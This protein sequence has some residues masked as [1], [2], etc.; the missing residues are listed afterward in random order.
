MDVSRDRA[1]Q[2]Y[3]AYIRIICEYILVYYRGSMIVA[4][5]VVYGRHLAGMHDYVEIDIFECG[6]HST[7][8]V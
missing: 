6:Q 1:F 8:V 7:V 5:H 4:Q 2:R 3:T